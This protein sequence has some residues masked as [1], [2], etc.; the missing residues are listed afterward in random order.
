MLFLI[1]FGSPVYGFLGFQ[2]CVFKKNL[3]SRGGQENMVKSR[4]LSK[5]GAIIPEN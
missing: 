3:Y 2:K 4:P 5:I 1:V